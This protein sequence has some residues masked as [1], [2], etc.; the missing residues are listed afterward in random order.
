[1]TSSLAIP[2]E[3]FDTQNLAVSGKHGYNHLGCQKPKEQGFDCDAFFEF[4]DRP[5]R[6][7]VS[8]RVKHAVAAA[9]RAN[10][11]RKLF[12]GEGVGITH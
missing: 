3:R 5:P 4:V 10:R 6:R 1:M 7:G 12:L 11:P 9:F 2:V 8:S